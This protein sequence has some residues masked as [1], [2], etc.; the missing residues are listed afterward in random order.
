[1]KEI[2]AADEKGAASSAFPDDAPQASDKDDFSC[3]DGYT[4]M[5][6]YFALGS[7]QISFGG[8]VW[9]NSFVK[10]KNNLAAAAGAAAKDDGSK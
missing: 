9:R 6:R 10:K 2:L 8:I 3:F 7:G 5:D 4:L 1:M